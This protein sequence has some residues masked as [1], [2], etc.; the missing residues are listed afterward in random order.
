MNLPIFFLATCWFFEKIF[1]YFPC[2]SLKFVW[3]DIWQIIA[4]YNNDNNSSVEKSEKQNGSEEGVQYDEDVQE[5]IAEHAFDHP[6]LRIFN[7][8]RVITSSAEWANVY[9]GVLEV[10]DASGQPKRL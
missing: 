4:L 10:L 5:Q 7:K 3:S 1:F 9:V 6:P 2:T 8:L